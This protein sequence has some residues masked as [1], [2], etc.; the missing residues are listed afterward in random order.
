MLTQDQRT[1]METVRYLE[2]SV[3]CFHCALFNIPEEYNNGTVKPAYNGTARDHFFTLQTGFFFIQVLE[4]WIL[5]NP[6]PGFCKGF[7]LKTGFCY[8]QVQF[9]TSYAIQRGHL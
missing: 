7:P 6:E 1:E 4:F 2:M 9:K 5:E 3:N 8:F